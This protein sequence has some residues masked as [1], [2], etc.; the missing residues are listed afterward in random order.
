MIPAA[1]PDPLRHRRDQGNVEIAQFRP[2]RAQDRLVLTTHGGPA[3]EKNA[4]QSVG[5]I[6]A[7]AGVEVRTIDRT[8][9]C[10]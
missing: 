9:T 1:D 7:G 3:A 6:L 2:M 5:E 8:A 10:R 4:S